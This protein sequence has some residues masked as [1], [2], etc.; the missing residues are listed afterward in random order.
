MA[1]TTTKRPRRFALPDLRDKRTDQ[2]IEDF[3][4]GPKT[5]KRAASKALTPTAA[6]VCS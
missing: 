6:P 5:R 2:A 4:D 3:I 1:A